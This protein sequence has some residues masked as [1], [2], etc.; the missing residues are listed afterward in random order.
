MV[1]FDNA[2]GS[3]SWSLEA[4]LEVEVVSCATVI[5]DVSAVYCVLSEVSVCMIVGSVERMAG[6]RDVNLYVATCAMC[7]G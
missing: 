3:S 2:C 4:D 1:H 5:H 6:T 7:D